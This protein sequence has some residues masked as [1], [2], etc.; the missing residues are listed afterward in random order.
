MGF[1]TRPGG[2]LSPE[3]WLKTVERKKRISP[4]FL[5]VDPTR[6]VGEM[7]R[8]AGLQDSKPGHIRYDDHEDEEND[9]KFISTPLADT[10]A[11]RVMGVIIG[12]G[13]DPAGLRFPAGFR[14]LMVLKGW[15]MS[16]IIHRQL[17]CGKR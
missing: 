3:D 11:G 2:F 5:P 8:R 14:V 1:Y 12:G 10:Q 6:G 15:V 9:K 13:T 16:H 7:I 4:G 17:R